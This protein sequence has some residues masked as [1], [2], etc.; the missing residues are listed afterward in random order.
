MTRD[1][2][3]A[4]QKAERWHK[5]GKLKFTLFSGVIY[6][7]SMFIFFPLLNVTI[8]YWGSFNIDALI[9]EYHSG[10]TLFMTI[11]M[12]IYGL[13]ISQWQW[14]QREAT[15]QNLLKTKQQEEEFDKLNQEEYWKEEE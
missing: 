14:K 13:V 2:N 1:I 4:I 10:F 9:K 8:D 7:L 6:G 11:G 3:K 5:R 12:T 15:Y